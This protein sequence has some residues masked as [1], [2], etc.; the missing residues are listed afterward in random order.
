MFANHI[1]FP[2]IFIGEKSI[3]YC[4]FGFDKIRFKK[5]KKRNET[6][7]VNFINL[8]V[9]IIIYHSLVKKWS[10]FLENWF[11]S[12]CNFHGIRYVEK[13]NFKVQRDREIGP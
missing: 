6:L 2:G 12:R 10:Y 3:I 9:N 1:Y 11:L 4:I 8:I 13:I 5:K 7:S